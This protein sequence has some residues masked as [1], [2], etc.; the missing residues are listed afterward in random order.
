MILGS[1]DSVPKLELWNQ[2]PLG[3]RILQVQEAQDNKSDPL[4]AISRGFL[5]QIGDD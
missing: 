2:I 1:L 3:P 5:E 4:N